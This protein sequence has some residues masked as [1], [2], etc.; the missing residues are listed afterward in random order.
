MLDRSL[1]D[2]F[3]SSTVIRFP[4]HKLRLILDKL[5][6]NE[7]KRMIITEIFQEVWEKLTE[8]TLSIITKHFD[9]T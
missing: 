3:K 2:L 9:H 7:E 5:E 4:E 6:D 8:H 1:L